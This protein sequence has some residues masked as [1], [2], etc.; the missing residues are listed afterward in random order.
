M[1]H[2][3]FRNSLL[4][5]TFLGVISK[6]ALIPSD[7]PSKP[8]TNRWQGGNHPKCKEKFRIP[9]PRNLRLPHPKSLHPPLHYPPTPKELT[10]PVTAPEA[11]QG[12][13]R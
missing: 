11:G 2:S 3:R 5:F 13:E 10:K 8:N 1:V 7:P 9:H 6:E 4:P 12:T